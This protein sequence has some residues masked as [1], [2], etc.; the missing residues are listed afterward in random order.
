[1]PSDDQT[2]TTLGQLVQQGSQRWRGTPHWFGGKSLRSCR[3]NQPVVQ[4]QTADLDR[5]K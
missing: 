4:F 5:R 2:D 3:T 1:M